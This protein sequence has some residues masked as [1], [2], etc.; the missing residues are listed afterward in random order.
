MGNCKLKRPVTLLPEGRREVRRFIL[1]DGLSRLVVPG[2]SVSSD[3][4]PSSHPHAIFAAFASM[5]ARSTAFIRA[6]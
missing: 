6:W 3:G 4:C 5:Y 2:H 1:Q